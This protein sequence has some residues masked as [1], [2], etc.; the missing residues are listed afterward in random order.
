MYCQFVGFDFSAGNFI[1]PKTNCP[2]VYDNIKLYFLKD[3]NYDKDSSNFGFGYA[4]VSVKIKN[5]KSKLMSV[6]GKEITANQLTDLLGTNCNI[7]YDE[8]KEIDSIIPCPD[9]PKPE[10]KGA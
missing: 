3:N 2:V 5:D 9:T 1:D 4:P 7:Y 8:K 10:K 6:F